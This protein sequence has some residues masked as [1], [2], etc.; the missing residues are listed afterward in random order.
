VI[1]HLLSISIVFSTLFAGICTSNVAYGHDS[2]GEEMLNHS[3]KI[4][5]E[6]NCCDTHQRDAEQVA[7]LKPVGIKIYNKSA[8]KALQPKPEIAFSEYKI[9]HEPRT[10]GSSS[11]PYLHISLPRLE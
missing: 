4:E 7:V 9:Q 6:I 1:K 2:G 8:A 10:K 3:Q 5:T 11:P